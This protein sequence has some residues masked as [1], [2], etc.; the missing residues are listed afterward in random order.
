LPWFVVYGLYDGFG[1]LFRQGAADAAIRSLFTMNA[2]GG[3]VG[4]WGWLVVLSML[5]VVFLPRQFQVAVVENVDEQHLKKAIWLFPLYLI[6]INLFV[7]PIAVAGLLQFGSAVD[8]D[9][10][11]LTLPQIHGQQALAMLVFIGGFSAATSMVLVAA[12]ALSTMICNDLVVPVLL[13]TSA[14]QLARR[15]KVTGLLLGIRRVSI[16]VV[17][18]MGY[19][20]LR[21][22]AE[23]YSLVSIGLISFAAVAQFAPAVL[24]GIFW[25]R[26]T[27]MGALCGLVAGFL[28]W[29]YTL[30]VPSLVETGWLSQ[31]IIT[32]G[33]LGITWLH[34]YHL[35]GLTALSYIPHAMFWS[36]L[37]NAGLYLGVSLFTRQNVIERSQAVAFVDVFKYAGSVGGSTWRGTAKVTDLRQLLRRFLG[38]RRTQR[39]LA[40]YA[41]SNGLDEQQMIT[42]DEE[43]VHAVA[44]Q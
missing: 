6:A 36:L 14:F 12:T 43:L 16:I 38:W 35:F 4:E 18:V 17:L 34:P 9:T 27:R 7:L 8:A 2:G 21:S 22:V 32:E 25:K 13:H 29:S 40:S 41:R 26:G 10:F 42:A 15:R 19:V 24:G 31:R 23:A 44:L 33:P 11:V 1:D 3:T 37:F 28:L 20:Y 39:A 30:L 5:A